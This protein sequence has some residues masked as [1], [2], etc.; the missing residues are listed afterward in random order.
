MGA[1]FLAPSE[2]KRP[3]VISRDC[4]VHLKNSSLTA[5]SLTG[6]ET[7]TSSWDAELKRHTA[8]WRNVGVHTLFFGR[9]DVLLLW[10]VPVGTKVLYIRFAKETASGHTEEATKIGE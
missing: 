7:S 9:Q 5:L 4:A 2:S 3:T 1:A 8:E 10:P 6:E